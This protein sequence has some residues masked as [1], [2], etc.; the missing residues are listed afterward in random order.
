M[1]KNV[2]KYYLPSSTVMATNIEEREK[3]CPVNVLSSNMDTYVLNSVV[4][5]NPTYWYEQMY[6]LFAGAEVRK[7]TRRKSVQFAEFRHWNKD[8]KKKALLDLRKQLDSGEINKKVL[9]ETIQDF[10]LIC[11]GCI[12]KRV[13]HSAH[14]TTIIM[15][16]CTF[17]NLPDIKL[18]SDDINAGSL[19][20]NDVAT[21]FLQPQVTSNDI[22]SLSYTDQFQVYSGLKTEANVIYEMLEKEGKLYFGQDNDCTRCIRDEYNIG[23]RHELKH[24]TEMEFDM[25]IIQDRIDTMQQLLN[26]G[27]VV[28]VPASTKL[29]TDADQ[30]YVPIFDEQRGLHQNFFVQVP[31]EIYNELMQYFEAEVDDDDCLYWLELTKTLH[32]DTWTC[33]ASK[34]YQSYYLW[35]SQNNPMSKYLEAKNAKMHKDIQNILSRLHQQTSVNP[36]H[37]DKVL[38]EIVETIVVLKTMWIFFKQ[39]QDPGIFFQPSQSSDVAVVED[40]N[41]S[42][43][44]FKE[45]EWGNIKKLFSILVLFNSVKHMPENPD[46]QAKD[47]LELLVKFLYGELSIF[48]EIIRVNDIFQ[49]N[50]VDEEQDYQ[51]TAIQEQFPWFVLQN[52]LNTEQALKMSKTLV[53]ASTELTIMDTD[54]GA[55]I[56]V[57]LIAFLYVVGGRPFKIDEVLASLLIEGIGGGGALFRAAVSIGA[58][59]ATAAVRISGANASQNALEDGDRNTTTSDPTMIDNGSPAI[60]DVQAPDITPIENGSPAIKD[61]HTP[62]ITPIENGSPAIEDAQPPD[63][64]PIDNDRD[65]ALP[66][67]DD[68]QAHNI[69]SMKS[70][71]IRPVT[72][73]SYLQALRTRL[74]EALGPASDPSTNVA[75]QYIQNDEFL[76]TYLPRELTLD[77][78]IELENVVDRVFKL[79]QIDQKIKALPD[80]LPEITEEQ[81]RERLST[82]NA[83]IETLKE[84]Q[85]AIKKTI[86]KE[87]A[88]GQKSKVSTHQ[89]RINKD[90]LHDKKIIFENMQTLLQLLQ[91]KHDLRS[92]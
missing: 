14:V 58:E 20:Y 23:L 84:K 2:Y 31:A 33:T 26:T 44:D 90:L 67:I 71:D 8:K 17:K 10:T 24:S 5:W 89:F 11:P 85:K 78:G 21:M 70:A 92:E 37:D 81:A 38:Q 62:D 82:L 72:L 64:T 86:I 65:S 39:V 74:Q 53:E 4:G 59:C 6:A 52:I 55:L 79:V 36:Y 61:A 50:S 49:E 51:A 16:T 29:Y 80:D 88:E 7:Q 66:A 25:K 75:Y 35:K 87:Q 9:L 15:N 27:R 46:L 18:V 57:A 47:N 28:S 45:R 3:K 68:A 77:D 1:I 43:Q 13:S 42:L 41:Q 48:N 12:P 22:S 56:F 60:E 76:Q 73:D 54:L 69:L 63:I 40:H 19:V 30:I 83:D 34:I 32:C 91:A